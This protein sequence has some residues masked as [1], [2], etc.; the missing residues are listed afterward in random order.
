M[1]YIM[2]YRLIECMREGLPPDFD[3]YDAAAWSAPWPLSETS[4]KNGNK[5]IRI[6]DFT[7][8]GWETVR[9]RS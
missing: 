6:S 1:D 4:V 9:A 3:V 5:P 8:G 2:A 7:R